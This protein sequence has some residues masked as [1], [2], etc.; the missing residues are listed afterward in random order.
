MLPSAIILSERMSTIAM[1]NLESLLSV[2]VDHFI[3]A[4]TNAVF[5]LKY[6][7][8]VILSVITAISAVIVLY[9]P[10]LK[11]PD[12]AEFQLFTNEHLFEQYD[13][14]YKNMFFFESFEMV[15]RGACL[16]LNVS[17]RTKKK[18]PIIHTLDFDV[19]TYLIIFVSYPVNIVSDSVAL[20]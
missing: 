18:N 20:Y 10:T 14:K 19:H 15:S 8:L 4:F 12:T 3:S 13:F 5:R 1:F 6:F 9:N 7:W 16:N 17:P 2:Y 11:L